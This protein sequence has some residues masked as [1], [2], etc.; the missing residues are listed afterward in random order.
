LGCP[1]GR[2]HR[3]CSAAIGHE[4]ANVLRNFY[5][6]LAP[7]SFTLLG[8]WLIVVQTRH[9]EWRRSRRSRRRA[10]AVWLQFALPGL[11]SL[12]SLVD[13][14]SEALW[15]VSFGSVATVGVAILVV[16]WSKERSRDA[17]LVYGVALF[18]YALVALLAAAPGLVNHFDSSINA[19]RTEA[20][21]LSMLIFVG[22]N[23]AW[24][25]LFGEGED[26]EEQDLGH[27]ARRRT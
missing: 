5:L 25:L 11:M 4:A 3:A 1:S 26:P 13:T 9:T 16:S 22:V 20:I 17:A 24:L 2:A 12:L 21:L 10:Y 7:V 15:R 8:L 14:T 19:L 18:L 6:A 27:A 23:V